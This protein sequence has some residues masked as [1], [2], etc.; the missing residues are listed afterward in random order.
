M[1]YTIDEL[2]HFVKLEMLS[3]GIWHRNYEILKQIKAT[4]ESVKEKK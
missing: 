1:T 4:L 3:T 2:I